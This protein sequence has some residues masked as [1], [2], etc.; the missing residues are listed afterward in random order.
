MPVLDATGGPQVMSCRII[1]PTRAKLFSVVSGIAVL[2]SFLG[3]CAHFAKLTGINY[4]RR[5]V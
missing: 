3:Q 4:S 2:V 5:H 1:D